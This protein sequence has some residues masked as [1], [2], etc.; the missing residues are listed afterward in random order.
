MFYEA[1]AGHG[2]PF[3]PLKAIVAPRPI[4]WISTRS[5]SG[6]L[7]LAP[8]SFFNMVQSRP[9]IV[10]FSAEGEKDSV[11]FARESSEFV[12]NLVGRR[13]I[14]RTVD[15]AVDAP[16]GE[17]EFAY[18]GLTPADCRLVAT[19]RVAEAQAA[20]ECRVTEVFEPKT[21]DGTHGG[22]YV[23]AGQVVG[24]HIDDDL[25]VDGRFDILRAGNVGRLG[26]RD[27]A[28]VESVFS[29]VQPRWDAD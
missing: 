7:N 24:V 28:A 14:E 26:Y 17:S 8:Y 27:Y 18:A 29:L 20:L 1:S 23:V 3:D 10:W 22:N 13:I 12:A 9:A 4:G 5:K 15:S 19:P 21:L 11:V 6:A 16:R 2:L 25:I